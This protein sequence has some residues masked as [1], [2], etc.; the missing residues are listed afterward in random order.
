M[1]TSSKKRRPTMKDLY[2]DRIKLKQ[3]INELQTRARD[4]EYDVAE[5]L[6][7]SGRSDLMTVN[8]SRLGRAINMG[9]I[10]E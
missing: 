2:R 1:E 3:E 5:K 9:E 6:L 8:W 4:V 7:K 10:I